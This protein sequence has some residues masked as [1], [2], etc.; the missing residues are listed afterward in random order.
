[1]QI[2]VE[3]SKRL[4]SLMQLV[5][6][7][8]NLSQ[9]KTHVLSRQWMS[10]LSQQQTSV[11]SQPQTSAASEAAWPSWRSLPVDKNNLVFVCLS[12][13]PDLSCE[14][15]EGQCH[16]VSILQQLLA[17]KLRPITPACLHRSLEKPSGALSASTVQGITPFTLVKFVDLRVVH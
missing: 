1:M 4:P 5:G 9:Q 14:R 12:S 2:R 17:P 16:Q 13:R 10:I 7:I 3:R 8:I 15:G 6:G 11:L